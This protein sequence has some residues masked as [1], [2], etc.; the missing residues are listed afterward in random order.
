MDVDTHLPAGGI[1]HVH[2]EKNGRVHGVDV[3]ESA[4]D[5]QAFVES[6]LQ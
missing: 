3:W 4:E 5:F 2:Y 6:T 1:S